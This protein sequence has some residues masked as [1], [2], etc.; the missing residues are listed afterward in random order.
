M[1]ALPPIATAKAD[2]PQTACPLY[3]QERTCAVQL[4]MSAL[5]HKRTCAR[6]RPCPLYPQKRL[7]KQTCANGPC[8]LYPESGHVRCKHRCPLWANSGHGATH[9][10]TSS[11]RSCIE[12]GTL[13]PSTFA[14]PIF[15]TSSYFL[16]NSNGKSPGFSPLTILAT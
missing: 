4:G 3:P 1:S 10:I 5:G 6:N 2:M 8:L 15:M 9:S 12:F 11:A 7:K 14:V 16:G 13:S